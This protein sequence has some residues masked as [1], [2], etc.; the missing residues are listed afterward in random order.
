[1]NNNLIRGLVLLL[2]SSI[3]TGL[4]IQFSEMTRY[5]CVIAKIP[6]KAHWYDYI[7]KISLFMVM[8]SYAIPSILIIKA[9]KEK[10]EKM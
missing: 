7:N 8:I 2:I 9:L 6:Y 1:M 3:F 10:N 4:L 5:L